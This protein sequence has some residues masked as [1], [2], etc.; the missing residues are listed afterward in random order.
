MQADLLQEAFLLPV[1][2]AGRV[3][4]LVAI[5][6]CWN[7]PA[8]PSVL[9]VFACRFGTGAG[10]CVEIEVERIHGKDMSFFDIKA[11]A[12]VQATPQ[13]AWGV[14][15]DYERLPKFVPELVQSKVINRNG[16]DILLEQESQADFLFFSRKLHVTLRVVEQPF[17]T[18]HIALVSGDMKEC[19]ARWE[20]ESVQENGRQG[21]RIRYRAKMEPAFFIPPLVGESFAR[22][23]VQKTVEAVAGEIERRAGN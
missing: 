3:L 14:L 6:L 13:Q 8:A 7:K 20:L 12:F 4:P 22:G 1:T 9:V 10:T 17:S 16:G 5:P 18:V 23:R 11:S 21:T 15:T 19:K 2:N